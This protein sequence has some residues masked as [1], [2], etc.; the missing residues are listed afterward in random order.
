MN[1]PFGLTQIQ[2]VLIAI[3]V[4]A[5]ALIG[6]FGGRIWML[7]R[8]DAR[9]VARVTAGSADYL[10]NVLVPDGNGG[11]FHLDFLLLTSRGVVVI[12]MR[13]VYQGYDEKTLMTSARD[14]HP[15]AEG[16]RVI[17]ARLLRE[18][19]QRPGLLSGREPIR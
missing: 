9:R 4:I 13:D 3:G 2:L 7:R 15:N 6:F 5:V 14:V 12:D 18:L 11:D 8:R 10:R 16:H 19:E 17:A 1:P